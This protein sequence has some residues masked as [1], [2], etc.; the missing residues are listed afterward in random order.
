MKKAWQLQTDVHFKYPSCHTLAVTP[1]HWQGAGALMSQR[2]WLGR[3][4]SWY[5]GEVRDS[6]AQ[7]PLLGLT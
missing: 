5:I 6:G 3:R 1:F 4:F 2:R 7:V